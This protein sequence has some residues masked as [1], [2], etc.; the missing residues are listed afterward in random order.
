MK[1]LLGLLLFIFLF[2]CE[3][4]LPKDNNEGEGDSSS[5]NGECRLNSDC[6]FGY[7][8]IEE[9]CVELEAQELCIGSDCPC[10][11]DTDCDARYVCDLA[12]EKCTSLMCFSSNECALGEVCNSGLCINQLTKVSANYKRHPFSIYS[13]LL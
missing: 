13:T 11:A 9:R 10:L 3:T 12:T 1:T 7:Q 5:F 2:A 8:C 6:E 4:P